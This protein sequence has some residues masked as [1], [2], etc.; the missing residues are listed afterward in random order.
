MEAARKSGVEPPAKGP[1]SKLFGL[2]EDEVNLV[3]LFPAPTNR[4]VAPTL[5]DAEH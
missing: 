1:R 5:E 2:D 3:P 4:A